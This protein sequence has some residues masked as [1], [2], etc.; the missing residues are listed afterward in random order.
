M[1]QEDDIWHTVHS[2]CVAVLE[3]Y[4]EQGKLIA[5]SVADSIA[6]RATYRLTHKTRDACQFCLGAKGGTPGNENIIGGVT[7]CDYCTV[8]YRRMLYRRMVGQ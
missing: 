8:L 1:S 2:A 7:I 4:E 6:E 5:E 3:R